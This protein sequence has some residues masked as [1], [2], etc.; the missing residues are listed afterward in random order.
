MIT[1]C[2]DIPGLLSEFGVTFNPTEWTLFIDSGKN[3]LKFA[4]LNNE[5]DVHIRKPTLIVAYS[6]HHQESYAS[7]EQ[8]LKLFDNKF[9]SNRTYYDIYILAFL[10]IDPLPV[11]VIWKFI[12][13]LETCFDELSCPLVDVNDESIVVK[14]SLELKLNYV[15]EQFKVKLG[16]SS[17]NKKSHG[18]PRE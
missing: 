5:H 1:Y 16:K 2:C 4:I 11:E 10:E 3:S 17:S 12:E 18:L 8:V 9:D 7:L 13:K 15:M 14:E 6:C